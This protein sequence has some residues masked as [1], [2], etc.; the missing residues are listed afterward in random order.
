MQIDKKYKLEKCV[1]E[2]PSRANLQNVFISGRHAY[3]TNGHILAVVP[4]T[5]EKGDTPGWLT[6]DALKLARKEAKGSDTITISLNG[7]L[8][9]PGGMSLPRPNGEEKPPRFFRVLRQA[10]SNRKI[11]IGLNASYLKELSEAIGSEEVV[12]EIDRPDSSILVR[13]I[14]NSEGVLGILMPVR[15]NSH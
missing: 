12:L 2:D 8:I 15:L 7:Q 6:P 9:L 10:L 14:R 3:A 1:S 4:V 11:R 13:P 5:S